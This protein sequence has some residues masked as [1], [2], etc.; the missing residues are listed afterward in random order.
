MPIA[1]KG[2]E[3]GTW[4]YA[5]RKSKSMQVRLGSALLLTMSIMDT[6]TNINT[7]LNC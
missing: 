3:R 2:T 7:Y 1:L 4:E 6:V 5:P